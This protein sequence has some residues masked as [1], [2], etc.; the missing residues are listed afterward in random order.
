[1]R[2]LSGDNRVPELAVDIWNANQD[3]YAEYGF[4]Q[5]TFDFRHKLIKSCLDSEL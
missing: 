5:F 1:M 2:R 4:S 3:P